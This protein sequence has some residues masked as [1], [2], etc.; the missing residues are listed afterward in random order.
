LSQENDCYFITYKNT[1]ILIDT[2]L[3]FTKDGLQLPKFHLIDFESLDLILITNF[4]NI[5]ALPYITE[6][7]E[8]GKLLF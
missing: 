8:F 1:N 4:Y 7:T 6:K 3:H 2:P 5:G